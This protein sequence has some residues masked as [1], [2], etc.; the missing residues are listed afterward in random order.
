MPKE[1]KQKRYLRQRNKT[2]KPKPYL[3]RRDKATKPKP[4][5]RQLNKA[6]EA[7]QIY[8]PVPDSTSALMDIDGVIPIVEKPIEEEDSEVTETDTERTVTDIE[9]AANYWLAGS[10]SS[11]WDDGD[12]NNELQRVDPSA[13]DKM[14]ESGKK[15]ETWKATEGGRPARY[16]GAAKKTIRMKQAALKKAAQ[17]TRSI[18]SYFSTVTTAKRNLDA[19][20]SDDEGNLGGDEGSDNEEDPDIDVEGGCGM[21]LDIGGGNNGGEDLSNLGGE[22]SGSFEKPTTTFQELEDSDSDCES[23]RETLESLER[24]LEKDGSDNRLRLVRQYLTLVE[25]QGWQKMDASLIIAQS[26]G[27]GPYDPLLGKPVDPYR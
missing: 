26:V 16:T 12:F 9:E 13:F 23:D 27:K 2:T 11:E 3:Q 4:G 10:D 17:G 1:S 6:T 5:L 21:N 8:E 24:Y 18:T 14:S 19:G 22:G 25:R 15:R 20:E 7:M